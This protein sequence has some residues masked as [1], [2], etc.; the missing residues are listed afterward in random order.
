MKETV[1]DIE[2]RYVETDQMGI[3][4]HS[5]Y[6]V[7]CELGRTHLIKEFGFTYKE[8]EDAGI[9]SPVIHVDLHYKT[10]VRYGDQVKLH[11]WIETYDGVRVVYGYSI[12]N[13]DGGRCA[14]GTST[15]VCVDQE[16][17]RPLS[18]KKHLPD[19]H[20]AYEMHKK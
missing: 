16:S 2:V 6:V 15:H 7:W 17:F 13:G 20:E 5:N 8:L 18:I 19:W 3:V 11:T 1:T 9:I 14:E 10:P 4:H 12:I